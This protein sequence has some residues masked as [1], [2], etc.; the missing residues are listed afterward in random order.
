MLFSSMG[1]QDFVCHLSIYAREKLSRV[2]KTHFLRLLHINYIP[3][4]AL[5]ARLKFISSTY[6]FVMA[7]APPSPVFQP[8]DE[9][10][11]AKFMAPRVQRRLLAKSI[12]SFLP[13]TLSLIRGTA[14]ESK[15]FPQIWARFPPTSALRSGLGR[16]IHCIRTSI[17]TARSLCPLFCRGPLNSHENCEI[18]WH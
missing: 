11:K 1:I 17:L 15:E 16:A 7:H 3:A 14:N 4:V 5:A 13:P 10:H 2:S 9:P 8:N 12:K 18:Q 6:I